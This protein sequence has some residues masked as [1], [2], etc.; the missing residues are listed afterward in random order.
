MTSP[1]TITWTWKTQYYLT[2]RTLPSGVAAIPGE[3]W[4]DVSA[5]VL[6]SAPSATGYNF[7]Y[8]D[9]DGTIQGA[10]VTSI[11]VT[12]NAAHMATAHY[13][14]SASAPVGGR[15]VSFFRPTPTSLISIYVAL[16]AMFGAVMI[17][18][19]RKRKW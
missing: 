3:G 6:L 12:L 1:S 14:R 17:L 5:S 16:V 2:V 7:Q 15:T 9:V 10:N 4:Y 18:T 13:S 19:R 11:T 8:W